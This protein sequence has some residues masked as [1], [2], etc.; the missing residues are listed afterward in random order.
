MK[1][2]V[3]IPAILLSAFIVSVFALCGALP[4]GAEEAPVDYILTPC[5]VAS[6]SDVGDPR[7]PAEELS[8]YSEEENMKAASLPSSYSSEAL[9]RLT[10]I[11]DQGAY[12]TCWAFSSINCIESALITRGLASRNTIDLS[13]LHLAY[14]T[15]KRPTD[16]LGLTAGDTV[17]STDP[18][19]LLNTGGNYFK[20]S[21]TLA[22]GIGPV[23]EAILPYSKATSATPSF[24]SSGAFANRAATIVEASKIPVNESNTIKQLVMKYGSVG[25]SYYQSSTYFNKSTGAYYNYQKDSTNH[26]V[27]IVG[28][29]D[30]YS[31]T[32]FNASAR[33]SSNG[34]WLIKNSY[35]ASYGNSGYFWMS[36][37]DMVFR[38]DAN[39]AYY[40]CYAF[41]ATTQGT[42]NSRIYQYDGGIAE[43]YWKFSTSANS[44][45]V[46]LANMF[47]AKNT[48]NLT[49]ASIVLN[50][51]NVKYSLQIYKN[52][53][54]RSNPESGTPLLMTPV[55]GTF[56]YR[57]YHRVSIPTPPY[58]AKGETF[59]AVFTLTHQGKELSF[60]SDPTSTQTSSTCTTTAHSGESFYYVTQWNDFVS[61]QKE[62]LRIKVY[63]EPGTA[64][65]ATRLS[66]TG[67]IDT[68]IAISQKGWTKSENAI[69]A[70]GMNYAD[71]LAS[72]PL[73]AALDCPILLTQNDPKGLETTVVNE[74]SHLGV[75]NVYVI[76][77]V[78][79]V[80]ENIENT[81]RV[82][83]GYNVTRLAGM[84]RYETSIKI[85]EKL[86][87][88][89]RSKG[90]GNFTNAYFCSAGSFADAL[91]ISPV[92][93][94][95]L[96][97][98]LYAPASGSS[99][100]QAN[101][102]MYDFVGRLGTRNTTIIG[103]I[104]AVSKEA[105]ADLQTITG[106]V[107]VRV[108]AGTTGGRYE[109]MLNVCKKYDSVFTNKNAVCV[110]TGANFPDALAGAAFAA[111]NRCP[112]ILVGYTD[113]K[114][115]K[116]SISTDL[117]NYVKTKSSLNTCYIFGGVYAVPDAQICTLL[118]RVVT[119]K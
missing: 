59:A 60:G 61:G 45:T 38:P 76:G 88:I 95:E 91:A 104:Y 18:E 94:I 99:L 102:E 111:K 28:W 112:I 41:D 31:R 50:T 65:N 108:D 100:R 14:Y 57:G 7:I 115:T 107:P 48:E 97:P 34:A 21:Q 40:S 92:A 6:A 29:N 103:G 80:S 8:G 62:N 79:V 101:A 81:L 66:G 30:N 16:P 37:E 43:K 17:A 11:K 116:T 52:P 70:Y 19:G 75:K 24:Q 56:E 46:K 98:I 54:N 119:V 84:G 10:S 33:P 44:I 2:Y 64:L 32:N 110:A 13:E 25:L 74:L 117:K 96:N 87:E 106:R 5:P 35:G 72:A 68:A 71:A 58:V 85:A 36:Y 114:N 22:S 73:A 83:Y 55:T 20:S 90:K 9:G 82:K 26:A 15:Y 42:Q 47:T 93:G 53:T 113:A 86:L 77:G 78:Y 51:P 118:D 89:R 4:A 49:A 3:R 67:R 1:K 63:A 12:G 105:A 109:T 39:G 27:S 69:L 23:N